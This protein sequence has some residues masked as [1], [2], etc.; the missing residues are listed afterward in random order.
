[1]VVILGS[2]LSV[3][4]LNLLMPFW[5]VDSIEAMQ[6]IQIAH[7]ALGML[8]FAAIL[9]HIYIGSIGMQAA[10]RAMSTGWVDL[11]WARE[12]H[13]VWVDKYLAGNNPEREGP[14]TSP[15]S[16]GHLERRAAE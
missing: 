1:M 13:S 3:S 4:G 5:F 2:F 7:A 6:Y 11:N 14:K 15:P 10:F 9:A 16:E 12:H 8:M